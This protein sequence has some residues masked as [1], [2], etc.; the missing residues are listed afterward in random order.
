MR[1]SHSM[2][3]TS[4]QVLTRRQW[5]QRTPLVPVGLSFAGWLTPIAELLARQ[6]DQ[7]PRGQAATSLILLWMAGAP[8]Q[9]ETFDPHPG[10]LIA[11][12]TRAIETSV[13]GLRV[14]AG[15]ERLAEHMQSA[16]LIRSMVS[17]EGDHERATYM[18]KTGY[19]PTPTVVHPSIGAICCHQ[20]AV[21]GTEIPRH[22]SVLP[23][24][25]P[26]VGGLLGSE[27]DAF[28]TFDPAQKVPDVVA[29]TDSDRLDRRLE[30]LDVV[31]KVFAR[32]RARAAAATLHRETVARAKRM[33]SSEQIA[34]FDIAQEPA[35]TRGR[36]G[37]TPFGRGCL[38]A[39]RLI[40]TG[41]RCVEVTL[42]GWDSHINNHEIQE[43]HVTIL[44]PAL[45]SL[46]GDL[47]ERDLLHK[48]VV[49]CAGE[50]GRTP[51]I[52]RL[53]GR[54][55]WPNGFSV[56]VAG[57]G[58]ASGVV[59][60]ETDPA[61]AAKPKHPQTVADLHATILTALGIDPAHEEMAAIGRPIKFS[62]G[63]PI[64][65]LLSMI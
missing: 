57:G 33:M 28:Q 55:H 49:V 61:G 50:F 45:A 54:D 21:G 7:A 65:G 41:V 39:R 16:A 5:L 35:A 37:D 15:F 32:G 9:L 22:I 10:T 53:D 30:D 19:R 51:H 58:F 40:E 59:I 18:I 25:W 11:G 47:V 20:L 46:L 42:D 34:A 23:S 2:H 26:S 24:Q 17:K 63:K 62:D 29:R 4:A 27:F 64:P 56:F 52:N 31:E 38:A 3:N 6:A 14:A 12:G 13:P 36:Y 43:A 60:G 8:S 1:S 48:T 44:D